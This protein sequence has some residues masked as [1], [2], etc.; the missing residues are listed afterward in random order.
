MKAP[1][2]RF[3]PMWSDIWPRPRTNGF[4]CRRR[5]MLGLPA[6]ALRGHRQRFRSSTAQDIVVYSSGGHG[7]HMVG[8]EIGRHY[9]SLGDTSSW[10]GFPVA[11]TSSAE[12]NIHRQQGFEK[13]CIIIAPTLE[14][15]A[16][17]V[18]AD[19]MELI[20]RG[21]RRTPRIGWPT[22]TE[23]PIGAGPDRVQFFESGVVTLRNGEREVW[24][25]APP[26]ADTPAVP[27]WMAPPSFPVALI[28][29]QAPDRSE[30]QPPGHVPDWREQPPPAQAMEPPQP[31]SRRPRRGHHSGP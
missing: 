19:T 31:P 28:P 5:L 24:L 23:Q 16:I 7:I 8:P 4:P 25:L 1:H 30:P 15:D 20:T 6:T 2:I 3:A 26:P 12:D 17:A 10:L 29:P 27:G 13:G 11:D 18:P 14:V 22:S 21:E 9:D